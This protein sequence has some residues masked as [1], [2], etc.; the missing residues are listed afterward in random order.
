MCAELLPLL[1][2]TGNFSIELTALNI[3]IPIVIRLGRI[4]WINL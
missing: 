3:D 4:G 1:I 2:S